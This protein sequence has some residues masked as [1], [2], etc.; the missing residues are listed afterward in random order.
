MHGTI[1]TQRDEVKV[2]WKCHLAIIGI[3]SWTCLMSSKDNVHKIK[4]LFLFADDE[5]SMFN[6]F[7][8]HREKQDIKVKK[9]LKY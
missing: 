9:V 1:S 3:G 5:C 7:D 6:G 2:E 4:S 8:R